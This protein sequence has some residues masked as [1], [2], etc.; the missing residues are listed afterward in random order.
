M[1]LKGEF[2]KK[3]KKTGLEPGQM[4]FQKM[5]RAASMLAHVRSENAVLLGGR[6]APPDQLHSFLI[7]A[8][9]EK[10]RNRRRGQVWPDEV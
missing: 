9:G 10:K 1:H 3:E 5:P 6:Q 4:F 7:G 2:L 8:G